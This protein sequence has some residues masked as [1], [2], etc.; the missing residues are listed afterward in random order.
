MINEISDRRHW[1]LRHNQ[2]FRNELKNLIDVTNIDLFSA[3]PPWRTLQP[4]H[5]WEMLGKDH[6]H[7]EESYEKWDIGKY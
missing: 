1:L 3:H 4:Y 7:R 6:P 5:D 2:T